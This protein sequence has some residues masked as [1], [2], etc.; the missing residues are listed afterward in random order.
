MFREKQKEE[1]FLLFGTTKLAI[2]NQKIIMIMWKKNFFVV[3]IA[4]F[5]DSVC[6][7]L[8]CMND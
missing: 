7:R 5:R 4:I 3:V 2:I 6:Y 1:T 8:S